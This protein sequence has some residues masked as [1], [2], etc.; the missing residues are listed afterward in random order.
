MLTAALQHDYIRDKGQLEL[1]LTQP[2]A[3][4]VVPDEPLTLDVTELPTA[5]V[6]T[7]FIVRF[8]LRTANETLGNWPA[9]VKASVWREVWVAS[10]QLKRGDALSQGMLARERR[11]VLSLHEPVA[12]FATAGDALEITEAVPAGHPL[13]ACMVKAR[14]V[15]HR[16]QRVEALVQDGSMSIR[17]QVDVLEDGAPGETVHARNTVTRRE[18]TGTVLNDRTILISL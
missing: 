8:N 10:I 13:L 3:S 15:V 7:A 14:A 4:L 6:A 18:L 16:G 5:G 2:R 1:H 12:D 11:D 17:T 9:N